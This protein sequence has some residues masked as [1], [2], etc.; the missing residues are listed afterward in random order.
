MQQGQSRER[1]QD[2]HPD[3]VGNRR[4]RRQLLDAQERARSV[5]RRWEDG[6]MRLSTDEIFEGYAEAAKQ[7]GGTSRDNERHERR[8]RQGGQQTIEADSIRFP[9]S[10]YARWSRSIVL[11]HVRAM[12]ATSGAPSN[13]NLSSG[14]ALKYGLEPGGPPIKVN[15]CL[16]G[17][18]FGRK[19]EVDCVSML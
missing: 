9:P 1:S 16:A 14:I 8:A 5:D 19:S 6:R 13:P 2:V 3:F 15:R 11:A 7:P 4:H 10:P 18:G 17:G 12:A